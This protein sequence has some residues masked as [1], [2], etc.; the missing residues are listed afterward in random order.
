MVF[1]KVVKE[2][3]RFKKRLFRSEGMAER[4]KEVIALEISELLI[5]LPPCFGSLDEFPEPV[6][7]CRNVHVRTLYCPC[8]VSS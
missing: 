3:E 1:E 8:K 2:Y 4:L 5:A 7:E 6:A